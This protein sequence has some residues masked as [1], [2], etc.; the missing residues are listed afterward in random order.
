MADLKL[1][2]LDAED[3]SVLSAHLQDAVLLRSSGP[4]LFLNRGDGT[5]VEKP[6]ALRRRLEAMWTVGR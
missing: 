4:L 2:A 6:N 3:L 1:I 5:F